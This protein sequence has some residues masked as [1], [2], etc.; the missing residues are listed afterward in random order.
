MSDEEFLEKL[1]RDLS[2]REAMT[3]LNGIDC[4]SLADRY[5]AIG[6][7]LRRIQRQKVKKLRSSQSIL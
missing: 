6:L 7:D 5:V 1:I 4:E 3:A 2:T